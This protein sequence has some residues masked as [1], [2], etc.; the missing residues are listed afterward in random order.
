LL[1]CNLL[2]PDEK[3]VRK[4]RSVEY[5]PVAH[6]GAKVS[7]VDD[8]VSI[9]F[10]LPTRAGNWSWTRLVSLGFTA[11]A[12]L[13][14]L[15][16]IGVF[17]W[18][19]LP[20]WRQFGFDYILGTKW[21]FRQHEFGILPMIYG[22]VMVSALAILLA[23]PLGVGAAVFTAEI[24][25]SRWRGLV[26]VAVELLAG[27]PS[28]VYGLLG[29]LFLR[30]WIY[31]LLTPF[32]PLSGDTLLTAG[33]L[34]AVMVL[35]TIITLSDDAIRGV[36][37]L[38]RHAARGLGLTRFETVT[39]LIFPQAWRGIFAS[40]LLALGRAMGETV[41][42]FLV[43]GRRDNVLPENWYSL[44]PLL[45][46]GQTLTSK[47]GGSETFIARADPLHWAAI[48]GL[49]LVLMGLVV[50]ITWGGAWLMGREEGPDAPVA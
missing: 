4:L 33:I 6:P 5:P 7:V 10:P 18:E 35:P 11:L 43:I 20:V 40:I 16:M 46:A 28:V 34:L 36:P 24:L 45:E 14:L 39:G 47:L 8:P 48:V 21:F 26:K 32:D 23:V 9:N 49:G 37:V 12:G 1:N 15:A 29:I 17:L 27:V 22:T 2:E 31:R 25:P 3:I 41:A 42:V 44:R 50:G 13:F 38:Q 30:D 19:S